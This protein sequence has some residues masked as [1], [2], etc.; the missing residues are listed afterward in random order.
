M[1]FRV[2]V[3]L[4]GDGPINS[5]LQLRLGTG[6]AVAQ[7]CALPLKFFQR[8]L[9]SRQV[10]F[11]AAECDRPSRKAKDQSHVLAILGSC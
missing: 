11:P 3:F 6:M 5:F 8:G 4:C 7:V 10:C 1:V 2:L 9:R